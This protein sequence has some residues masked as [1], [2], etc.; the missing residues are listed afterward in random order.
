[1][2]AL[3]LMMVGPRCVMIAVPD[4]STISPLDNAGPG[5]V[6]V[7][8]MPPVASCTN[9]RL[10]RSSRKVTTART[11]TGSAEGDHEVR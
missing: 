10:R 7:T 5:G 9:S 8:N 2:V 6:N 3:A 1:M 4:T 11:C